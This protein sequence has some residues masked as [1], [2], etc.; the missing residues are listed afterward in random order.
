MSPLTDARLAELAAFCAAMADTLGASQPWADLVALC[1]R[2][3]TERRAV[4]EV[5]AWY[6]EGLLP[7][8]QSGDQEALDRMLENGKRL[9]R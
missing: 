1:E 6:R 2:F 8:L 3:A 9:G 7:A 5:E 4:R